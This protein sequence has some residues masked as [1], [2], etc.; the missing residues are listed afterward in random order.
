M[1]ADLIDAQS[2]TEFD[3]GGDSE[4]ESKELIWNITEFEVK[5]TESDSGQGVMHVIT[6]ENDEWPYPIRIRR[7][8]SYSPT[9]E[10]K[11]TDWVKRARGTL[12][13][14]AKAATG[15]ASYSTDPNSAKYLVGKQVKATTG[16]DGDG[17]ATLKWFKKVG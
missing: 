1:T 11:N 14:I 12:K 2:E 6:F 8:V 3:F 4:V 16:E 9:D 10:S 15:A 5:T 7:F 17:F 13:K